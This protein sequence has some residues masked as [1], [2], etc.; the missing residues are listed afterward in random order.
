MATRVV[1]T[2]VPKIDAWEKVTG[3][4]R[5]GHDVTLPGML[6]GKIL[7]SAH[8][9]A[10]ILRVDTRAAE[11]VPG[12]KCVL[13]ADRVRAGKLGFLADQ[14][15]LKGDKARCVRDEIAAVAAAS[16][17]AAE[18][19]CEAIRVEYEPLPA[20]FDPVEAMEPG[21]PTIHEHAPDNLVKHRFDFRYG[22]PERALGRSAHVV[23]GEYRT[24]FVAHCCMEP[25]FVLATFDGQGRLTIHSTTQVPY[26]MQGHISRAL[27]IQGSA[28]RVVQPAIG[29]AFGSK[30]D[31]HAYEA[32]AVLLARHSG[33]P[34]RILYTRE[35]E[36]VCA[37]T[38][39][40]MIIRMATGCDAE[41]RLTAR[42]CDATL[43]NGA[44]ASWGATTPHIMMIGVSSLYRVDNVAFSARSVYTNNPWSGAFRG[45]GNPQGTFAIEQQM[46]ELAQ[47]TGI[48]PVRFRIRNA[49]HPD[50]VTPQG[51]RI[52]TCALQE[53]LDTAATRIGWSAPKEPWEGVGIAGMIHVGGGGRVYKSDGCGV[54][55]KLDDFGR[56]TLATGATEIGTGSDTAMAMLAAEELGIPVRNVSVIN[57]DTDV[58]PWDVGIHASRTTFIAG[59][60]TIRACRRIRDRLAQLAAPE[61]GCGP[62]ALV[63]ADGR[64]SRAD[65]ASKSVPLDRLVRSAHFRDDGEMFV[66]QAFYDPPNRFQDPQ[67]RGNV[68]ATYS[69]AAHAVRVRVDPETGRIAVLRFV[70]AHDVGKVINPLGLE[71]QIEGAVAQGL[72]FALTEQVQ[73]AAGRMQNASFLDYKM[74]G[75]RDV[76]ADIDLQFIE[77]PDAEGP[78]GAKGVSE[79][80]LIPTAAAVANAVA[81]AIGC[82]IHELP[83]TPER[84]LAAI[85]GAG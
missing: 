37:P 64:V 66:G 5:Y 44:Y 21:A 84:V 62:E 79:A 71:G 28:I 55:A 47:R 65:D 29:G 20:V 48:D 63:F 78:Y 15:V 23:E 26:L 61:L 16:E 11:R 45:Y 73:L 76:P 77:K 81:D 10:R 7:R 51:F 13:T 25:C 58:G 60:A 82:R 33:A 69:F 35:E 22:D 85:R 39:Q 70:A 74:L 42:I 8:P 31:T 53:C 38:K 30:L 59:N 52:T 17:E 80:G 83:L 9:H 56:L 12:V 32:I 40:P 43:D 46:D 27:G 18:E 50:S 68:S 72:G 67:W 24:Q 3:A 2:R 57:N 34:V 75:P 36:F 54:I 41:G 4:V 19:A 49:N 1:G 14:P 6:H